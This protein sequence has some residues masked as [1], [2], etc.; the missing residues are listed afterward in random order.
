MNKI[1]WKK[2]NTL[3]EPNKVHIYT[4]NPKKKRGGG[5][6][7]NKTYPTVVWEK[8]QINLPF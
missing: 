3:Q 6:I 7:L 2:K 8:K 1:Y 5:L 4:M